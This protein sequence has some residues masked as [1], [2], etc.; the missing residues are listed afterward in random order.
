MKEW[1]V[2]AERKTHTDKIEENEYDTRMCHYSTQTAKEE[3]WGLISTQKELEYSRY[4]DAANWDLLNGEWEWGP[5]KVKVD[6]VKQAAGF[7]E[8][9]DWDYS[10]AMMY[11][12]PYAK[13]LMGDQD[14]PC[15][16]NKKFAEWAKNGRT[17]A[18]KKIRE[19]EL[20]SEKRRT[21]IPSGKN[22]DS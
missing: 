19:Q 13:Y 14:E 12:Y 21:C 9:R 1:S 20:R 7:G 2:A 4:R 18:S 5:Q 16:P 11:K 3:A 17:T 22:S 6:D 8:Y 10:D 15:P